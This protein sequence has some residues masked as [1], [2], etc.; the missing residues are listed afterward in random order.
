MAL[1]S[2]GSRPGIE[3]ILERFGWQRY[4]AAV[5]T[6]EDTPHGKPA[7]DCFLLAADKLAVS[8]AACLVFEDTDAGLQAAANAG[9]K[10]ID[11]RVTSPSASQERSP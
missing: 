1:A 8:P 4:F 10:A 11:V 2:S 3:V 7:P 6:G 9:M 5:I